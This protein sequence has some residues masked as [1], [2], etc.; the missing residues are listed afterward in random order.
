MGSKS[1]KNGSNSGPVGI[2]FPWILTKM[3]EKHNGTFWSTKCNL[4]NTLELLFEIIK[5]KVIKIYFWAFSIIDPF[6]NFFY[7]K[8]IRDHITEIIL[9]YAQGLRK[10]CFVEFRV[11]IV[12]TKKD[13]HI[14][15]R[16]VLIGWRA[17]QYKFWKSTW[18]RSR[19][20]S[21]TSF[22]EEPVSFH[23]VTPIIIIASLY[24]F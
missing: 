9:K 17:N 21:L 18:S 5:S 4:F 10:D 24:R 16:N 12:A 20:I 3:N 15:S 2:N 22:V 1:L 23:D 6:Y 19:D 11:I 14:D 8:V 13:F 7:H